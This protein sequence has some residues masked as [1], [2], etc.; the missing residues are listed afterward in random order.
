MRLLNQALIENLFLFVIGA[1]MG[2]CVAFAALKFV[3]SGNYLDVSQVGGVRLDVRVLTFTAMATLATGLLFGLAPALK[4][5]RSNLSDALKTVTRGT[6]GSS[7]QTRPRGFLVMTEIAFSLVLLAG[8]GLM[9]GSLVKL[10]NVSLGFNPENVVT[11]R[12]SLPESRYSLSQAETLFRQLQDRVRNLPC[13]QAVAIANQL[14]MSNVAANASFDVQNRPADIDINVADTQIVSPDYFRVMEISLLRGRAFT[15]SDTN[16]PPASVIVNQTLARRVWPGA[17]P[18]GKRIRLRADASWLSVIGIAAD[19]KNH[20]SNVAT[21]P[22]MYFLHTDQ[23]FGIWADLRSVTFVVRTAVEPQQIV[24][25]MRDQLRNLDSELPV[26]KIATLEEVVSSSV[27]QT[28][29]PTIAL[30]AFAG[31][32]LFLS[33]IGVYGVLAYTVAQSRHDIGVR[34]A[35]GARR[36]QILRLF[37]GRGIRWA[38]IGGLG[39]IQA[40]LI[41]VRFMRS[42]LFG[43]SAYDPEIFLGASAILLSVVIVSAIAPAWHAAKVDPMVALRYE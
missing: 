26:F 21:K 36:E 14:P 28:R 43:I 31:I 10:T 42:M 32:A 39:G 16:L 22:E 23:P 2:L 20:G 30:C 8:A 19:I 25:A 4:A 38:A 12:L 13:V 40:A 9:I 7:H 11:M 27:S 17:N 37:L 24:S 35:L 15:D 41:L 6:A 3:S 34:L 5:S 33:A 29:F 18:I 1:F